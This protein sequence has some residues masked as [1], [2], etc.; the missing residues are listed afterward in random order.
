MSRTEIYVQSFPINAMQYQAA[1]Y[2]NDERV[3]V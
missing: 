1:L 2:L 3:Y